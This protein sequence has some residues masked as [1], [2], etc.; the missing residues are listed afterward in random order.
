LLITIDFDRSLRLLAH[1]LA[2]LAGAH[3]LISIAR[4]LVPLIAKSLLDQHSA[5]DS[6]VIIDCC[7]LLLLAAVAVTNK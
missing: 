6:L 4:W 2:D 3:L 5:I 1:L 7:C